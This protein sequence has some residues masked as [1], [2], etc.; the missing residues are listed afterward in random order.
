MADI[1]IWYILGVA[2]SLHAT[3]TAVYGRFES[4]HF[5]PL[6][7][8]ALRAVARQLAGLTVALPHATGSQATELRDA[9]IALA[10]AL[11]A[12]LNVVED[13]GRDARAV[14]H[15]ECDAAVARLLSL[16]QLVRSQATEG[17]GDRLGDLPV[18]RS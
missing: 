10:V 16:V 8:P 5:D 4:G 13:E 12:L 6:E 18:L 9:T 14:Y 11:S 2:L 3:V 15:A 17:F 7:L 1:A